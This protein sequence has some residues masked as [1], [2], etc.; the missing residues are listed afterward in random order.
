[1][2]KAHE[3]K[4]QAYPKTAVTE[5]LKRSFFDFDQN[6]Q[7]GISLRKATIPKIKPIIA[8]TPAIINVE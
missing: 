4:L 3:A 1:M 6:Q 5:K 2:A 8:I 7:G